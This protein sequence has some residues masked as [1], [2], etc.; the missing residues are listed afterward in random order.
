MKKN[1]P[2]L[3]VLLLATGFLYSPVLS[4]N[5]F[6]Q[7]DIYNYWRPHIDW[8]LANLAQGEW[9]GWN[10]AMQFG[11][12]FLADPNFQ[13][14][15]PPTWLLLVV[16]PDIFYSFLV[17]GHAVLAGIGVACLLRSYRFERGALAGAAA[18]ALS[19]PFV[20]M[21][22]LW[23]HY[24]GAAWIPWVVWGVR[25]LAL[26]SGASW[27]PMATILALQ[28]LAGSAESVVMAVLLALVTQGSRLRSKTALGR[29]ALAGILGSCIAAVQWLPAVALLSSSA[30]KDFTVATKLGWSLPPRLAYQ[31]VVAGDPRT[32]E[33]LF[34]NL[35]SPMEDSEVPLLVG[36]YLGAFALPLLLL[37]ARQN[38]SFLLVGLA[39]LLGSF[40]R[41]LPDPLP[42]W[43][44]ILPF[45]Y[46]TKALAL[47]A[48]TFA[49][50]VGAGAHGLLSRP[51][52]DVSASSRRFW[53][54][55]TLGV[56][57]AGAL[58][59]LPGDPASRVARSALFLA[60]G[61]LATLLSGRIAAV[62]LV[63]GIVLDARSGLFWVNEFAEPT[64]YSYR[65]PAVDAVRALAPR[66]R[67]FVAY[68]GETWAQADLNSRG[69]RSSVAFQASLGEVVFPPHGLRFGLRHGFQPDFSGLGVAEMQAFD[70]FLETRFRLDI[71]RYL[72]LGAIDA[73]ISTNNTDPLKEAEAYARFPGIMST[74][75]RVDRWGRTPRAGLSLRVV[76]TP[77]IDGAMREVASPSFRPGVDAV[78]QDPTA[79][80]GAATAFEGG[81]ARIRL[82]GNDRVAIDVD[83]KGPGVLV[84]RDA[85]RAGWTATVNGAPAPILRADVLFRAVR[86]PPGRSVVA[87]SY[88][89]PGLVPGAVLCVLGL[90]LLLW[91]G[92]GV[93][94]RL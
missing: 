10:P 60:S 28:A 21:A 17:I 26:S 1:T 80:P 44:T 54:A 72:D 35:G 15:Y 9:L 40:G 38:P 25:R 30:R 57:I 2:L 32:R 11:M 52:P 83:S 92:A 24:C 6:F 79:L 31:F 73:V 20:S 58:V 88:T 64:L 43:L 23:H 47:V 42:T 12:P 67:V 70:R 22:N 66:P 65:P 82:D 55:L 62:I 84:L 13:I 27:A 89:T 14:L 74:L 19:G 93:K 29:L 39:A 90:S 49:F 36:P 81:T 46:P 78:L 61:L 5:V 4:G 34:Q 56:A 59:A 87:F 71:R 53:A 37:G 75:T 94:V 8:A 18:M 68:P 86:V 91:M 41:Y 77:S 3:V 16:S 7:R 45:R 76:M 50:L 69:L 63:A 33:L 48:V 85:L 51:A